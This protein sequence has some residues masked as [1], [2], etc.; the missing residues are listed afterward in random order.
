MTLKRRATET[1]TWG[2]G[3]LER[4]RGAGWSK[5]GYGSGVRPAA[6]PSNRRS[7]LR[8]PN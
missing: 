1:P 7:F 2:Y 3:K 8:H 5:L 4:E 6:M